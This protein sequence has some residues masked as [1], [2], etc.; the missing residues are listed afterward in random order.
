MYSFDHQ[1]KWQNAEWHAR[2]SPRKKIACC[3][4]GALKVMHVMFFSQNELVLDH[5][6]QIATMIIGQCY[7]ILL[8]DKVRPAL[9]HK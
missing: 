2:A 5:P 4:Q 6:M 9:C 8:Q 7:Y 1:L 3:N